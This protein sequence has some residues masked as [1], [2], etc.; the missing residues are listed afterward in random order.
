MT[1]RMIALALLCFALSSGCARR[2]LDWQGLSRAV[3][4]RVQ[5]ERD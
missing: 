1:M 2:D 3:G 5:P 4:E